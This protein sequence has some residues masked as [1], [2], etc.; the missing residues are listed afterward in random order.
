[1]SNAILDE[2]RAAAEQ[3]GRREPRDFEAVPDAE[4][5]KRN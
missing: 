1:M 5:A 4:M 2:R 3:R